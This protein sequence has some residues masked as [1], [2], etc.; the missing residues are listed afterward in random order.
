[1]ESVNADRASLT[2]EEDHGRQGNEVEDDSKRG[3][4]QKHEEPNQPEPAPAVIGG[5]LE[6]VDC[7]ERCADDHR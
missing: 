7:G 1:M 6:S 4:S 5:Q 2:G 3:Q